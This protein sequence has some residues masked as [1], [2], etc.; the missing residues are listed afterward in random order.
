MNFFFKSAVVAVAAFGC[1]L[2]GVIVQSFVPAFVEGARP[3]ITAVVGLVSTLVSIVLGLLI[4]S[5]YN[6]FNAQQSDLQVAA[7][8]LGHIE[9][10]LRN[11]GP[12]ANSAR[13]V[14]RDQALRMKARF[15]PD[16]KGVGRRDVSY[17]S[18]LVDI[19]AMIGL[20][21]SL[22]GVSGHDRSEYDA[23]RVLSKTLVELQFRMVQALHNRML[24]FLLLTI[25]GWTCGLFFLYGLMCD[26]S[27]FSVAI[28]GV[29]AIAVSS[30]NFLIME[31]TDP[32]R[33][34]FRV[35]SSTLDFLIEWLDR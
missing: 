4:S 27:V 5:T 19:E 35:S 30:A 21:E 26:Q 14:L 28:I 32:Y 10:L 9:H 18:I 15:W 23:I 25:L 12:A 22:S 24:N 29:G 34:K 31:L 2:A 6:S 7:S 8:T 13:A 16:E 11:F 3:T 20:S 33:G 17:Q 1:G